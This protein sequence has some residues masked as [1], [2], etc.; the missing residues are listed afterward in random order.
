MRELLPTPPSPSRITLSRDVLEVMVIHFGSENFGNTL[1]TGR[2]HSE[3]DAPINAILVYVT[4]F[5]K[6]FSLTGKNA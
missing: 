6:P 2:D 1:P 4:M 3:K 5:R